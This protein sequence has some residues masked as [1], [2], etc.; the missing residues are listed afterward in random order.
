M[1]TPRTDVDEWVLASAA[2]VARNVARH[3]V[4]ITWSAAAE[5]LRHTVELLSGPV[6]VVDD[7]GTF[8]PFP[9]RSRLGARTH[10]RS[11]FGGSS[12]S[13][14]SLCASSRPKVAASSTLSAKAPSTRWV[15]ASA[16][17]GS[18]KKWT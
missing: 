16:L 4:P 2:E 9:D 8:T 7:G 13:L 11:R 17:D 6:F 18:K 3:G 1:S 12:T 15:Q 5:R 14:N 10:R